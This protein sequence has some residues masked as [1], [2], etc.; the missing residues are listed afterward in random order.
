MLSK[1][2]G[3][4]IRVGVMGGSAPEAKLNEVEKLGRLLAEHNLVTVNGGS[5]R[6]VMDY[7]S[8]GA[9][10]AGGL[11]LGIL[12]KD[13]TQKAQGVNLAVDTR[14]GSGRNIITGG[15]NEVTIAAAGAFGTGSE[16][17]FSLNYQTPVIVLDNPDLA[18]SLKAFP[19]A[20]V[21]E[22]KSA[23]QALELTLKLLEQQGHI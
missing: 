17:M 12:A 23:Q 20:P 18:K 14:L 15:T 5:P 2:T 11:V 22:V 1:K 19:N 7:V 3:A 21:H 6:G 10:Q 8:R 4:A 13:S 9:Q 16:A